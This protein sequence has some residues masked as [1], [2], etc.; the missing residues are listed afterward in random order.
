[1]WSW[2]YGFDS[3]SELVRNKG[4][5]VLYSPWASD[6]LYTYRNNWISV[7]ILQYRLTFW[8]PEIMQLVGKLSKSVGSSYIRCGRE[9]I[10][11]SYVSTT[12]GRLLGKPQKTLKNRWFFCIKTTSC[13]HDDFYVFYSWLIFEI[14]CDTFLTSK[15]QNTFSY[16]SKS[17]FVAEIQGFKV[18][19]L[20]HVK[21]KVPII[22]PGHNYTLGRW[23]KFLWYICKTLNS[24]TF[25]VFQNLD[26]LL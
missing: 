25:Y 26:L 9:W 10:L 20:L 12:H 3:P 15:N 14:F 7:S 18:T 11:D 24:G 19:P 21:S 2:T 22:R 5:S 13:R 17:W 16:F 6:H 4:S 8:T 1:M 23:L